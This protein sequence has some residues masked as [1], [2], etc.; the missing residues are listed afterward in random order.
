MAEVTIQENTWHEL[1]K[2]A[3]R[4][5]KKP[6]SLADQALREFLERHAD[7][8]LLEKSSLAAQKTSFLIRDTEEIIR[9]HRKR[10]KKA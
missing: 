2:A 8:E 3:R 6:E 7:E 4:Q 1:V 9:Q 5:R 10:K